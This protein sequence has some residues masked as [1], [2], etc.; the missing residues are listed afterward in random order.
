MIRSA[1]LIGLIYSLCIFG[2]CASG[3]GA[4]APPVL[5]THF[6]VTPDAMPAAGTSFNITVTALGQTGQTASSYNGTLHFASSDPQAVLPAASMLTNVMG[7]FP[8]T[9]KTA[10]PQTITVTDTNSLSGVSTSIVVSPGATSHFSVT[11]PTAASA[12]L[13]FTF[14]VT[15]FDAYNNIATNYAGLVHFSSSDAQAMLPANSGLT[16]GTGTFPAALKTVANSTITVADSATPSITGSS[17]SINVV[18]NAATHFAVAVPGNATTRSSFGFAVT[19]QDALNNTSAGYSGSVKFTSTDSQAHL[20][21]SSALTNGTGNFAAIFE[22]SG[23]QMITASDTVQPSLIGASSSIAVSAAAT[24]A[25]SSAA[26]PTGTYGVTY[27]PSES[28]FF[29]CFSQRSCIRCGDFRSQCGNLLN[30]TG[31]NFPC[32]EPG[33]VFDGFPLTATGGVSPYSWSAS[34]LPP[35]LSVN[36][37]SG[38]IFG[39][40]NTPGS[41]SVAISVADSGTP[42]VTAT[43][44]TY[45]IT[46]ND[47][48]PPVINGAPAPPSGVV[49]QPYS[50]TF[51]A[52]STA[53]PL[54]WRV[55]AGTPPPGPAL[56]PDGVLSGTP[57]TAGTSSFTLIAEDSFKQDSAPHDFSIQI[58]AHGFKPTGG[59]AGPRIAHTATLLSTGSVLVAGGTDGAGMPI[60]TAELY[61]PTKGTF[62]LTGSMATPRAHFAATPLCDLSAPPCNDKRVLVTGGL[63]V[64]GNPLMTAEL[65]DP[66][67]G[68][69]SPTNGDMQF[70]HAS[71]TATLLK[72][73]KVLVSGWGP[74]TAELFDPSTN[75]FKATGSMLAARVSHTATLLNNGNVLVAGGIG[76]VAGVPTVIAESELY[77]PVK[78]SFSQ[79]MGP[80]AIA[81]QWHAASLLAS[82]EVVVIGGMVDN[83]GKATATAELFDPKAQL[84]SP[85]MG[86]MATAR[87]FPTATVLVDGTVLV[88]GGDDGT[89][90]LASAEVYD[91]TAETFSPTG[92]MGASRESHTATLLNDGTVLVTGG[93]GGGEATAELYQ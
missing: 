77:D 70:V 85:T 51:T 87:A 54:I 9:L 72:T 75:T 6:S 39:T 29:R 16:N 26:P 82:G 64:N 24:L 46:I 67:T 4:P 23:P 73:G 21:A 50:F 61:D 36:T 49:N 13:L 32:I 15:A 27:G 12:T 25:I 7:T 40:P 35:G 53:S 34:G 91:P 84:F 38:E 57:T 11:G 88:T 89:G 79:T 48:A 68:K 69:F 20:P 78:G 33:R 92:G 19:A 71:H 93:A 86:K 18:S 8:A 83:A 41:F 47:P 28:E 45:P 55:S 59:M 5:A 58:F 37:Q 31:H 60:A 22:N 17:G 81:R 44:V 30:C 62:T 2:G 74:A 63:D 66:G 56:N 80:L 76:D 65:Y 14:T 3:G 52:A 1:V 42:Q 43:P 90:P 10:G